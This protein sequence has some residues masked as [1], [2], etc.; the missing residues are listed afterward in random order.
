MTG[1]DAFSEYYAEL[2]QGTYDCVDR[3][4]LNAFFPFGQTGGGVRTWWRWLRGDD[5]TLDNEHL[6][7]MAG[8]FSRRLHA[9]CAKQRIPLIEAQARDRKHQLAQLHLPTDPKFCG[10]F[11]VI[12]SNA[13]APIWEVKRNGAG[14]ITEIR[15]RKSWPYVRHFYFHLI[16]RE[17]GHVTIRICSYP[18]FGAQVI[19]NGH[20]RVERQARREQ[21]A[22]VKDG[23]CFIEGSDFPAINRLAAKLNRTETIALLHQLCERWVYSTCLCFALP[24]EER[25]RSHFT[26]QYSVFQLEL[27]RNLLFWRGTQMN[28]VYQKLIDRTR[29]TLTLRDVKTIFGFSHRPH[30]IA[31]RGRDRTEVFKAVQAQSYDL[32]V[33]KIK[34]G[35]LTLKIYD[36]G[37]RVLRIEVV[38]HNAKELR[39]GR[40][41]ERLPALLQRMQDMLVRFLGTIQAAHVSFLD[42]A[43]FESLTEPTTRGTRRLAGID[44]S[45]A[46]NRHVVDAVLKLSTKPDG[47][48]VAQLAEAVRP[49]S[50]QD[51]NTYS[52][53]NAAYDVAKMVGKKLL[54]RIE[55]SRRYAV[56]PPAI[57]TL[58][59]YLLLREKVIKP[60][61]AG[62]VRPH[63][64]PPKHC[65]ALDQHYVVLREEL[66]RTFQTIG[67]AATQP[68]N[69]C[70]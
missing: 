30:H 41:L 4:V 66:H 40:M 44:L 18:P 55:R 32:T 60:L 27:S 29:T 28:E 70:P 21:L 64:R 49:R 7:E 68:S 53:R 67:L 5:L 22:A 63:G 48:T 9:F 6:R 11:L 34:W 15:H 2:L 58:S 42:V 31:K 12:K 38:V 8:T 33:F 39:S 23:N 16:D 46:R 20:E 69:P 3:I 43:S 47:F 52:A 45:K 57:R 24:T 13:P 56:D 36:K 61:L 17:W 59:A 62:V 26:Y 37:G 54:R 25:S 50:G 14:Q 51:A 65:T 35:N 19:L 1:S 10:L